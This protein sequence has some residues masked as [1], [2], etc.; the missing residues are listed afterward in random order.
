MEKRIFI[1]PRWVTG[2]YILSAVVLLPWTYALAQKLPERHLAHHWDL[3]WVGFD[4][5]E[6]FLLAVTIFLAVKRSIWLPLA[7]TSLATV[8][9]LDAWF[10]VLTS[11]PG[12]QQDLAIIL[13]LL[14]ELPLA[15][16]TFYFAYKTTLTLHEKINDRR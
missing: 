11:K 14:V 10:D 8:L 7:A 2:L 15:I 16:L 3:A 6:V 1:F 9:V 13:A 12:S 5:F 4:I